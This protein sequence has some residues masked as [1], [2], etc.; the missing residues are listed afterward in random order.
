MQSDQEQSASTDPQPRGFRIHVLEAGFAEDG[1]TD[2]AVAVSEVECRSAAMFTRSRFAGASV[3]LSRT[4]AETGAA[5]GVVVVSRNANVATGAQGARDAVEV[6]ELAGRLVGVPPERLLI[7]STGVIGRRYPM[8]TV[9]ARL[10]AASAAGSVGQWS[11]FANTIMT[12]DTTAKLVR[13]SVGPASIVGV[14]KGV[15]MIEPNMATMLTYFFTDAEL[16]QQVLTETF[17]SVVE[18][19]FNALSIDSDTS[20]SDTAVLLANGLAGPVDPAEF[21][22]A[23]LRLARELVVRIARD[24]EGASKLLTVRVTGARD[25]DQA[26][27]V[28]KSVINSPLVKTA[29]HGSDPNWGRVVMAVGKCQDDLDI[30][31]EV[32]R[33]EMCGMRVYP[34]QCDEPEL[35]RLRA[36]MDADTVP[37]SID[38]GIGEAEFTV[39]GCDLSEGYV[40]LNSSY[41]T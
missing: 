21:R 27:R 11:D 23:L 34:E 29:V 18:V 2:L 36:L 24:G 1:R 20:T 38:L 25:R 4:V 28:G 39:Y 31:Q 40:R 33:V 8:S 37:I 41:T 3:L 9:R 17:R 15:G 19:S 6:R 32:V 30:D 26:K 10:A 35:E 14:A 22:A 13:A 5:Q 16:D 7:S 12:T